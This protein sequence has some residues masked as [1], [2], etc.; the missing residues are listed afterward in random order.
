LTDLLSISLGIN[1]WLTSNSLSHGKQDC[2]SLYTD[3]VSDDR[4]TSLTRDDN[5]KSTKNAVTTTPSSSLLLPTILQLARNYRD[6]FQSVY[7]NVQLPSIYDEYRDDRDDSVVVRFS[8]VK[9]SILRRPS[10]VH[11]DNDN[12]KNYFYTTWNN[13]NYRRNYNPIQHQQQHH[14]Q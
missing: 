6:Q 1:Y 13:W 5:N 10:S 3:E 7:T 9:P 8:Y 2:C 11:N 4:L 12:N 14:H